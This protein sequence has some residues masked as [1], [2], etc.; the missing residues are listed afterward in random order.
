[1]LDCVVAGVAIHGWF[2]KKFFLEL[3]QQTAE[4]IAAS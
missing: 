4:K 3:K 2:T 1:L